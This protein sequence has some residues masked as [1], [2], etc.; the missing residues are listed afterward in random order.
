MQ[1]LYQLFDLDRDGILNFKEYEKLLRC[2]GYRLNGI[3][4][5]QNF[6]KYFNFLIFSE[7][8][9]RMLA[10]TVSVDHTNCSLSFNE[11]LTLM[12]TQQEAEPN[13]ETLVDVFA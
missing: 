12:S 5:N 10:K 4:T 1:S 6:S 2:L 3:T 11:F 9:A 7:E 13:H 8:Q